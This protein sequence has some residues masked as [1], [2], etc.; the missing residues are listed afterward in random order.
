VIKESNSQLV[1][2]TTSTSIGDPKIDEITQK[3]LTEI[4]NK[5]SKELVESDE[6]IKILHLTN[7]HHAKTLLQH[8]DEAPTGWERNAGKKAVIKALLLSIWHQRLYFIVRSLIMSILGALLTLVFFLI[9]GSISLTLEIPFGI[10][11]FMF[12]LAVSRVLDV[13]IVKAS[14]IIVDFLAYHKSMRDF[15]LSHF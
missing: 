15:V 2:H 9:F 1:V 3:I 4:E 5:G 8:M 13:Q 7:I 10:F 6:M 14:R 12:T 11:S